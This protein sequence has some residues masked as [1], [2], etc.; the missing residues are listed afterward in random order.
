MST[1]LHVRVDSGE[2]NDHVT[3]TTPMFYDSDQSGDHERGIA[4]E[5]LQLASTTDLPPLVEPFPSKTD[6][7]S[8]DRRERRCCSGITIFYWSTLT[9]ILSLTVG[10]I[11]WYKFHIPFLDQFKNLALTSF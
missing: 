10:W 3:E 11:I 8:R 2:H 4:D 9:V 7:P 6:H 5:D 1:T